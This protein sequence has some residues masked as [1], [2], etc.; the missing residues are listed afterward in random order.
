MIMKTIKTTT[1]NIRYILIAEFRTVAA[2]RKEKDIYC[3][4]R[5]G[6]K[7]TRAKTLSPEAGTLTIALIAAKGAPS[8]KQ[9]ESLFCL[10]ATLSEQHPK[11]KV[12]GVHP[13]VLPLPGARPLVGTYTPAAIMEMLKE[14]WQLAVSRR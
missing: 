14:S 9:C 3:T 5:P 6:G 10:L 8:D 1:Y 2:V 7:I 12:M 13:A 4:I 11:A